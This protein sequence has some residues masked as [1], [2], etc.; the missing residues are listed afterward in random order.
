M[1]DLSI[2]KCHKCQKS[3]ASQC[4]RCLKTPYCSSECQTTDWSEHKKTCKKPIINWLTKE[5]ILNLIKIGSGFMDF[6]KGNI[7]GDLMVYYSDEK[8]WVAL[9]T[10]RLTR[11]SDSIFELNDWNTALDHENTLHFCF[12]SLWVRKIQEFKYDGPDDFDEI[13]DLKE[14]EYSQY[15]NK[16]FSKLSD[17]EF[18]RYFR[19][20]NKKEVRSVILNLLKHFIEHPEERLSY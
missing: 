14:L 12:F 13:L 17:E 16:Y 3:S 11:R 4:G 2:A 9:E 19:G 5:D 10:K 1:E 18:S 8:I 15:I 6:D 7:Y 20:Y